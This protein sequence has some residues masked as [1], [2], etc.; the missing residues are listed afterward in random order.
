[1][2]FEFST[3]T[4]KNLCEGLNHEFLRCHDSFKEFEVFATLT[5]TKGPDKRLS[6]LAYNAYA[7]FLHHLYEF[8][9]AAYCRERVDTKA[10]S[11]KGSFMYTDGYIE[12]HAQRVLT[13]KREGILNGTAPAWENSLSA[14]PEKIPQDFGSTLRRMR[15]SLSGHVDPERPLKNLSAYFRDHH[16]FLYL[17]YRDCMYQW[18]PK[19]GEF[20]NLQEITEFSIQLRDSYDVSTS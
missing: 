2:K 18:G 12:H 14:Y 19:D 1:M 4:D 20:P 15:N 9:L 16:G 13:N 5:V 7:R 10:T 3:A 6:Y 17:L 11:K 8:M